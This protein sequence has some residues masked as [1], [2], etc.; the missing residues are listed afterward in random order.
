MNWNLGIT[1]ME[2]CCRE[3]L[4]KVETVEELFMKY[5]DT[6]DPYIRHL[7][8]CKSLD[9]VKPIVRK[10]GNLGESKEDLLQIGYI[11]LIKAVDRFEV[12]RK[13]KFSTFARY[14]IEGEIRHYLRDKA[15]LARKPRWVLDLIKKVDQYIQQHMQEY[16]RMP[17]VKEIS[18]GLNISAEGIVEIIRVKNALSM[19]QIE[20]ME[21]SD[22]EMQKIKSLRMES[23][24]LPLEEKIAIEQA[25]ERLKMLEK[26]IVY[27]FFYYDLTQ[28]QISDRLGISQKKVSRLLNKAIEHIKSFFAK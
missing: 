21:T 17:Q 26:K 1:G 18:E 12:R 2:Y 24:K 11:G 22:V 7:I 23:F 15:E 25:I 19:N 4:L 6:G 9:L 20:D 16:Q 8:V 27:M 14:W 13:V 3:D 28:M 5:S 10:F